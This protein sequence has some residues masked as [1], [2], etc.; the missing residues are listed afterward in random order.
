VK[1]RQQ[2]GTGRR[3]AAVAVAW[4]TVLLYQPLVAAQDRWV[5]SAHAGSTDIDR[6]ITDRGPWWSS[7]DDDQVGLG[8][9]VTY[10]WDSWLGLR[11]LYEEADGFEAQ[12]RCPPNRPCPALA[13]DEKVDLT[14]WQLAAV[15]R[16]RVGPEWSVFGT[17]GALAWKVK[18]DRL[19]PGDSGTHF[20]YGGGLTWHISDR[21]DFGLEYQ[22]STVDYQSLRVNLGARF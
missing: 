12:N 4:G 3:I 18:R 16:W 13:F 5:L 2:G 6:L 15:P 1:H 9:S 20:V 17:A 19:L 11:L 8:V 14:A 7:V 21:I 22:R 10:E